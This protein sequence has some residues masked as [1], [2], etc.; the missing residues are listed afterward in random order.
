MLLEEGITDPVGGDLEIYR[1]CAREIEEA[2]L[3][4]LPR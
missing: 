3:G 4:I 2:I 1:R